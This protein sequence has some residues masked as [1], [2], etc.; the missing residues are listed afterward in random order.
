MFAGGSADTTPL[1]IDA[2][3]LDPAPFAAVT[4]TTKVVP[5]S[6]GLS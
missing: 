2:V 4:T 5:T 3:L 1:G 6:P